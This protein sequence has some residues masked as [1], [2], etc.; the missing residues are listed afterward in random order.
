MHRKVGPHIH[1]HTHTLTQIVTDQNKDIVQ[2]RGKVDK[3]INKSTKSLDLI[4]KI[5]T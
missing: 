2:K 5:F 3:E 4:S 1:T